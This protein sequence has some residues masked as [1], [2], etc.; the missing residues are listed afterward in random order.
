MIFHRPT[1]V[2]ISRSAFRANLRAIQSWISP[3]VKVL[4]VLKADAYGHGAAPLAKIAMQQGSAGIGISSL[5]EAIQLRQ[6][7]IRSP[8]LILGGV[9]PLSNFDLA[10]H[11]RI[12][13]TVAS[14]G[15]AEALLNVAR[16]RNR[17]LSFHLKVDTGMNRIGMSV[18]EAKRIL[19][20][21]LTEKAVT[22][23]GVYTHLSSADSDPAYT[24]RQLSQFEGLKS[25]A[26]ARGLN[27]VLFHAANS[28]ATLR[29]KTSHYGMVRPGLSL[30]GDSYVPV[31]PNL[32]ISSILSWKTKVIFLKKVSART[33]VSYGQT[34]VTRR[35]T[36]I[37]TLPVGYADGLPRA[38][39]N[40]G[41]VLI[42]GRKRP[43]LGRVTMDHIM[44]DVTGLKVKIG[45]PVV[46]IGSQGSAELT[47]KDWASW[48][49]SISYEIFCGI[50]KRVPRIY[51]K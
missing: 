36:E 11:H 2:E 40:K 24:R 12:T 50:S 19:D 47:A 9:Y 29:F 18:R 51:L 48:A 32:S 8:L 3:S 20:W 16:K 44:V 14:R 31:P 27:S 49:G 37:A 35:P 46:L 13:P 34:F 33:P 45:E 15:A 25:Y 30:Y 43:I 5:E 38:A 41:S 42:K 6:A 23:A 28:A 21:S 39:S 7:G 26:S 17:P 4:S 1:W 22:V 10:L